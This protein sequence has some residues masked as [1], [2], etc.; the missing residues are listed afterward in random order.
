MD[1]RRRVTLQDI[2]AATG[3]SMGTVSLVLNE[4]PGIGPATRLRVI[5]AAQ[6]LGYDRSA[7]RRA[8]RLPTVS[9]VVERLPLAP[10]SDPFN[11]PILHGL[12][13]AARRHGYRITMEFVAPGDHPERGHWTQGTTAGVIVL[14]G[15][16]LSPEWVRAAADTH[17]PVV[18]VDHFI[19]GVELPSVVPDNLSGAYA[20]TTY[21]LEM[22]HTR[23]GFIRGPS[24]YWTLG[25][26]LAGYM[27]ALQHA[28]HF[29]AAELVPPRVSHGEQ[30][31]YGETQH[32][33]DLPDPP[34]AIFAVSDKV[35]A[36]A[37][38]AATERGLAIPGDV[39]IVGFDNIELASVL[40]PPLTTVDVSG[41]TMGIV[42]FERLRT[43]IDGAEQEL[44]GKMRWTIPTRLIE[45]GSVER[46]TR[47]SACTP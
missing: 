3:V 28:G 6:S 42:A 12:E 5:E 31:G 8:D 44:D 23:I 11:R 13:A 22:G 33:L 40:N 25:E 47:S 45:R 14:G 21:L 17:L 26:R 30:K 32:L 9:M 39:S 29:P 2:A 24:K 19:P 20:M 27:L 34:T 43:L 41:E 35:A 4:K 1:G 10:T 36:G 37:Y 38:R 16:D 46:R 7:R 18:M 15:G